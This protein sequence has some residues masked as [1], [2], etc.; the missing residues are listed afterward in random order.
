MQFK[1]I[2]DLELDIQL[3]LISL[4]RDTQ[5][6]KILMYQ[7]QGILKAST[8]KIGNAENVD[9]QFKLFFQKAIDLNTDLVLT[10]EYSC[11]WENLIE[12]ILDPQK[13]PTVG[14]L[15]CLGC[16]SIS[17]DE[18][19]TFV[20]NFTNRNRI[21][22]FDEQV[23]QSNNNFLDPLV[24][25]FKAN[26]GAETVLVCLIQFKTRHMGVFGGGDIERNNLIQ[27][28]D[29]YILRNNEH[30][31][32]FISLICSE[33][34][35]FRDNLSFEVKNNI[36]WDDKPYLIFHPQINPDPAHPNFTSFRNFVLNSHNKELI[37]LNWQLDSKIGSNDMLKFYCSRSGF[38]LRS[39]EIILNDKTRIVNNHKKGLY[40][41][42]NKKNRHT[43]LFSSKPHCYHI[44]IPHVKHNAYDVQS[45]RDGPEVIET[46]SLNSQKD[47]FETITSVSDTHIDYLANNGCLNS[48]FN[49]SSKCVIDKERLISLSTA[50][51]NENLND[52][53]KINSIYMDE[54]NEYNLRITT[55]QDRNENSIT[56]RALYIETLNSLHE[57]IQNNIFPESLQ[58][59]KGLGVTLAY[60]TNSNIDNFKFNLLLPNGNKIYATIAYLV[61]C[62][63]THNNKKYSNLRKLFDSDSKYRE[64]VVIYYKKCGKFEFIYD[65]NAK[66]ITNTSDYNDE[67]IYK[68]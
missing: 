62:D 31:I 61:S 65:K 67:S 47:D 52:I 40:Y 36:N 18:L 64:R 35:N 44:S 12:L 53:D 20:H 1:F 66:S 63:D 51:V 42:N 46:F 19:T 45:R 16:E 27:G 8:H 39:N 26:K 17:K 59:L 15:W 11:P 37:S 56:I 3:D 49:D 10:P 2:E 54:N 57:I 41:F 13:Q 29:I 23:L 4:R 14:K 38:Y 43:Y 22:Y 7:H 28:N 9:S 25:L 33:A 34:M 6:Y 32:Y 21:I 30:S 48:Y 58:E 5:R 55:P 68:D 60:H 24:Y 50:N